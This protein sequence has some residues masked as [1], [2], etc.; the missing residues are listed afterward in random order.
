MTDREDAL[1]QRVAELEA[2]LDELQGQVQVLR[3]IE[4]IKQLK[5]RYVRFVDTQD[6]SAWAAEVLADDFV[7]ESNGDV[8][9][10]RDRAVSSVAELMQGGASTHQCH[11]PEIT[12]TGPDTASGIW[13]LQ[14]VSRLPA[15]G[16]GI[17]FRGDGHYYEEYVRTDAGWRV[18]WNT[19]RF[20]VVDGVGLPDDVA[21][22]VETLTGREEI[23]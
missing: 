7:H 14:D 21:D 4:E 18:R 2:R 22:P 12:I 8:V 5:A 16:S 10:G 9:E 1:A 19:A 23:A 13:S 17:V 15:D 6:W 20:L 11:T 3:D